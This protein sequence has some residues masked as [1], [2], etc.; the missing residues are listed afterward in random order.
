MLG[1]LKTRALIGLHAFSGADITGS[2]SGKG[3]ISCWHAIN[4]AESFVHEAFCKLGHVPLEDSTRNVIERY[5]C[6]FYQPGTTID[7]LTEL[8]WWMFRRK[9]AESNKLP[10]AKEG[11]I[12][13]PIMTTLP[14]APEA[15]LQ[16]LKYGCSKSACDTSRC[17]CKSNNL[18]CTDFCSCGAETDGCKNIIAEYYNGDF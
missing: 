1:D 3:K 16:L 7:R 18:Y 13:V 11:D 12:Y 10:P 9:Q 6:L 17:K 8:R 2:M 5:V 15:L 4:N 14:P